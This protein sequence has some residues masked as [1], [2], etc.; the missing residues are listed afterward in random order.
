[1]AVSSF[2]A[3]SVERRHEAIICYFAFGSFFGVHTPLAI[4]A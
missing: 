2:L 4:P 1:M 3:G